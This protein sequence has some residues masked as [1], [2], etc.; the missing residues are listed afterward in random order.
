MVAN[1]C[2]MLH[3]LKYLP[4]I[5][6]PR[7]TP[8]LYHTIKSLKEKI[9]WQNIG[10]RLS[11][12][13]MKCLPLKMYNNDSTILWADEVFPSDVTD[14]LCDPNFEKM[15]TTASST[16][17]SVQMLSVKYPSKVILYYSYYI[18][19]CTLLK[20]QFYPLI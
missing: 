2:R 20:G 14:I 12:V 1:V 7:I 9:T 18:I 10:V 17:L 11:L 15:K 3:S 4:T 16:T 19:H 5:S 8:W 13:L 6:A